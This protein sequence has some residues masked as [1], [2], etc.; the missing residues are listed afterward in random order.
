M[1]AIRSYY[2]FSGIWLEDHKQYDEAI[3]RYRLMAK[4]GEPASQ[5]A[6]GLW[7][8]GWVYYRT[9]QYREA[10]D[11]F[12]SLADQHDLDFEPQAL[13]WMGRSAELTKDTQAQ[14]YYH[15]VCQRYPFTYYCQL[16]YE[17]APISENQ[18]LLDNSTST[19]TPSSSSR[20]TSYN[21]CYT[22]LL[23]GY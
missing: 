16:A 13:Y 12:R 17:R 9:G 18:E 15:R 3:K 10:L 11:T 2:V 7:R 22:K 14:D 1:Y 6:E 19:N 23:R 5:R 4:Q 8:A 21:V 20:I